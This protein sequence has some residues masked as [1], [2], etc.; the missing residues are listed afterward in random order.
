MASKADM[1]SL[2]GTTGGESSNVDV[3]KGATIH[4]RNQQRNGKKSYTIVTG[5]P[6]CFK[7]DKILK[8]LKKTFNCNGTLNKYSI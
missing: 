2:F 5:I 1:D 8:H 3:S 4:I 6:A 7:F